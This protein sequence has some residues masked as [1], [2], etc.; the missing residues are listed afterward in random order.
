MDLPVIYKNLSPSQKREVREKYI[1]LQH[2]FCYHCKCRLDKPAP[3]DIRNSGIDK[4]LFPKT[5]FDY[6]IHLHHDH[7]TGLTIGAV[8]SH[9]NAWLWQ[10]QGE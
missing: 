6:P 10:F 2:G 7:D 3:E 8:H 1:E 5:M 4:T 9:C